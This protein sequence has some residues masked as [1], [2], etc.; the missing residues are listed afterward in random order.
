MPRKR[1][2]VDLEATRRTGFSDRRSYV[3]LDG[4]QFL[5]GEDMTKRREYV[6]SMD[7][8]RC[9]LC[10][11]EV[12]WLTG[13]LDHFPVSR[14]RS[15]DDSIN[16]LRTLCANCHKQRHVRPQWSAQKA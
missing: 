16:N 13:E 3:T 11:A 2:K 12:D 8:G 9:R 7:G 6:F 10:R 1:H 4:K 15:G 5:A 14:G